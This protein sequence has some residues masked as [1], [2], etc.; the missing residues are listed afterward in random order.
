MHQ[1]SLLLTTVRDASAVAFVSAALA[2][3][4][5]AGCAD[6]EA[7]G[8]KATDAPNATGED[9]KA[10]GTESAVELVVYSGRGEPLVGPI[11]DK[12]QGKTGTELKV[13]YGKTAELAALL[14]EEKEKSPATLFFAQDAGAL[15]AVDAAGLLE[16]LPDE[17]L[18][19]V[20]PA[21]RSK[22]KTWVGITGRA[23]TVVY[24][25]ERIKPEQL[26]TSVLDYT[27]A[28]WKGRIG[29]AP[30]NGSFQAF[31][32]GLR[33]LHGDEKAEAWLRGI[34]ANEPRVYPKN[35]PIVA[36]VAAGEID[37]G[38]V[39][40]YYLHRF[41]KDD[42]K[43]PAANHFAAAKDIG[44][45]VNVAGI[46]VL[47]SASAPQ[48]RAAHAVIA[49]LLDAE[50]QKYFATE[51]FEIPLASGVAGA[52]GVTT[53]DTVQPPDLGLSDLKDLKATLALLRKAEVLP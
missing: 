13:R 27:D 2:F 37:V 5:L 15:G 11:I 39:N 33:V 25:T 53:L 34:K 44:A 3:V 8:E 24:S 12:L 49:A 6:K 36:A 46:G 4:P 38:F 18:A 51:T 48:K 41:K 45:L 20:K 32:T 17:V 29:W 9:G 40:H 26:P 52:A 19:K 7:T 30:T 28:K 22:T 42:P 47:K 43:F 23:R 10:A 31:V 50:S 16:P 21:Y 14:L 35:T 1:P